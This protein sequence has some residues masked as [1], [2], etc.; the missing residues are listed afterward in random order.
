MMKQFEFNN[1]SF[2]ENSI[3]LVCE[4]S[5]QI[6]LGQRGNREYFGANPNVV[7]HVYTNVVK[8]LSCGFIFC[9]PKIHGLEHLERDHYN[10]PDLYNAYLKGKVNS[11]YQIG[12]KL[13]ALFKPLGK[14]LDI[15]AGKGEFLYLSKLKGYSVVG[16][17]PSLRFCEYARENYGLQVEQGYLGRD[18]HFQGEQFDVITLFHVLEH[19]TQPKEL[20]AYIS[21]LLKKD[22]IVYIEVPNADAIILRIADQ[23]F[24]LFGKS[25]S[26]RLSPLHAPF[27][28]MGYSPKSINYLLEDSGFKLVYAGTFSGKVRGYDTSDRVSLAFTFARN[29]IMSLIN[30][31]PSRELI[32]IVAKKLN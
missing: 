25:W 2:E 3:C 22:G 31:F 15:G 30:I 11:V 20:L 27:H 17:E 10:D 13:L 18:V 7:P 32:C 24:R 4:S 1:V 12:E 9:N 26:S 23:F 8:C 6:K 16:V 21:D 28:S 14:L 5:K 29:I 19:V